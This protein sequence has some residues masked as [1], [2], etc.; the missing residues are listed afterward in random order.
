MLQTG[1]QYAV[2]NEVAQLVGMAAHDG[3][4]SVETG[5]LV[6]LHGFDIFENV[7]HRFFSLIVG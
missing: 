5:M 6:F 1:V 3:F 2:G 7:I 4:C